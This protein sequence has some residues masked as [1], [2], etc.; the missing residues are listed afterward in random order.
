MRLFT[1]I[2][3]VDAATLAE[4]L[5]GRDV[6]VL[7]VR[8]PGEF[9]QGHIRGSENV[10]LPQLARRIATLPHERTIVAVCATGHRSASAARALTRAGYEAV[11]LKGGLRAWS[12]QGLPVEKRRR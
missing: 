1:R 12:R 2:G 11:N 4:R 6:L 10:P 8:T 5:G 9:R 3:H 7:D